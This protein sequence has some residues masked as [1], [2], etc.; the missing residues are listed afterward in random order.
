MHFEV[1]CGMLLLAPDTL[2][3]DCRALMPQCSSDIELPSRETWKG[4]LLSHTD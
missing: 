1:S 3:L 4:Y 2:V